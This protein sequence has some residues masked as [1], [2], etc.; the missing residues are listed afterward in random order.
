MKVKFSESLTEQE[1]HCH[2][3]PVSGSLIKQIKH[4]TNMFY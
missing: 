4:K 3:E 1:K 2:P